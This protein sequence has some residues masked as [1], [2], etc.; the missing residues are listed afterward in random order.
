M[1]EKIKSDI[2]LYHDHHLWIPTRT[3][4][5]GSM[6]SDAELT[7]GGV[8][9]RMVDVLI[10]N[11]D[12]LE[13]ISDK[14]IIVKMNNVGGDYYH[15]TAIYDRIKE[16]NCFVTIKVYGHAMSMGAIILQAADERIMMPE[17]TFMIHEGTD[18]LIG[19]PRDV[20]NCADEIKRIR[21]RVNNIFHTRVK[22][23]GKRISY[24]KLEELQM[25]NKFMDPKT[26]IKYGFADKIGEYGHAA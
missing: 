6:H 23:A 8:D 2:E 15:G 7:E 16:C 10:K 9:Y 20:E 26:A 5:M 11:L 24:K 12:I 19:H 14:P 25:F 13:D 4:S 17:S 1:S 21:T 22:E 3:I 18:G